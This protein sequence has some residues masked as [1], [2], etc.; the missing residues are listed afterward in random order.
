M[1]VDPPAK[2]ADQPP[3]RD[4]GAPL[5]GQRLAVGFVSHIRGPEAP[6]FVQRIASS[7]ILQIQL[8]TVYA[9]SNP[10]RRGLATPSRMD[11]VFCQRLCQSRELLPSST[12]CS[13]AVIE[14]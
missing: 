12:D 3:G 9:T 10:Q 8:P 6:A 14:A 7:R 13:F 5:D 1:P 2:R 11:T 4:L